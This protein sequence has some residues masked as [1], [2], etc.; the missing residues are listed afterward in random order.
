MKDHDLFG[1]PSTGKLPLVV[2]KPISV[3]AVWHGS[4]RKGF[5][6]LVTSKP[7]STGTGPGRLERRQ[8]SVQLMS[9]KRSAVLEG[10]C[11]SRRS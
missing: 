8:R 2:W 1:P 10:I 11:L 7:V 3:P 9:G 6:N 5:P 4:L